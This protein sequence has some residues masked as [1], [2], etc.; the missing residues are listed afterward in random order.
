[1]ARA[2]TKYAREKEFFF[3][4]FDAGLNAHTATEL[5]PDEASKLCNFKPRKMGGWETRQGTTRVSNTA[6]PGRFSDIVWFN[7]TFC[8]AALDDST[9]KLFYLDG[10]DDPVLIG[11]LDGEAS[12]DVFNGKLYVADG[13]T[14]MECDTGWSLGDVSGA[15]AL[16]QIGNLYNRLIGIYSGNS[17]FYYSDIKDVS[18]FNQELIDDADQDDNV[19]FTIFKGN[20]Y[21]FK[22]DKR[23]SI[24]RI[25]GFEDVDL[26]LRERIYE[27]I[28]TICRRGI[29]ASGDDLIWPDSDGF[30]SLRELVRF[31]GDYSK[32]VVGERVA[33]LYNSY[34]DENLIAGHSGE[35]GLDWFQFNTANYEY[36]LVYDSVR[37]VWSTYKF[38]FDDGTDYYPT[39][40]KTIGGITYIGGSNG[41][42]YKLGASGGDEF[43]DD[44]NS[45]AAD[46]FLRSAYLDFGFPHNK[47]KSRYLSFFFESRLGATFD[48]KFYRD[49][50]Y[51]AFYDES[52]YLPITGD[53]TVDELSLIV[54]DWDFPFDPSYAMAKDH[55][56][57]WRWYSL[58][59]G[60]ENVQPT[61]FPFIVGG[62][63]LK[64]NILKR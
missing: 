42:L 47:K 22:G 11:A 26:M 17:V 30:M 25:T 21:I 52:F 37:K 36:L 7:D 27:G 59:M 28:S 61:T 16:S 54:D 49:Y 6:G 40:I 41:H 45:Y 8:F 51:N 32:A 39:C 14:L 58:M 29:T 15:P 35:D 9:W 64:S 46:T 48:L 62:V 53:V 55:R 20:I 4:Q 2:E 19:A 57:S 1:M 43:K 60:I 44:G 13:T 34:A 23:K 3:N 31:Q 33:P 18:V 24:H 12:L 63:S 10:S 5:A 50:S 38:A 56:V